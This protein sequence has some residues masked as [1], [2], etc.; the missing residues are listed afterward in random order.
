MMR[1][2][3]ILLASAA[4]AAAQGDVS[5]EFQ[6]PPAKSQPAPQ[7]SSGG[8]GGGNGGGGN[9]SGGSSFLGKD[10]PF[11]DPGSE[12]VTWDGKSW[13]INNNRLV[14][15]RFEKYLNAPPAMTEADAA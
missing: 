10:T 6:N 14:E 8:G 13:N 2:L 3:V 11:F 5:S 12:I 7:Q 4:V 1:P 9:S 15:A